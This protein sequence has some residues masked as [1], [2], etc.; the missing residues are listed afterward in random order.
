M[1]KVEDESIYNLD[2]HEWL[3]IRTSST[4]TSI[5]RVPGGWIY[6]NKMF[7]DGKKTGVFVPFD[8]EFMPEK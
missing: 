7:E 4:S 8:N 3:N 5:L 1:K 2:L 6:Y